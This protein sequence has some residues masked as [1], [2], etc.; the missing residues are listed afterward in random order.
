VNYQD[1]FGTGVRRRGGQDRSP[2]SL[3]IAGA[4]AL[5]AIQAS[6]ASQSRAQDPGV[7]VGAVGAGAPLPGLSAM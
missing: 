6:V 4:A 5:L 7:R 2:A 1:L 3:L